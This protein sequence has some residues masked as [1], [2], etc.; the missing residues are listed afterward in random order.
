MQIKKIHTVERTLQIF[1][2]K[3]H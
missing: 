2:F 1:N 3:H